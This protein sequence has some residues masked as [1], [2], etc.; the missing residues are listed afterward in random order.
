VKSFARE[1]AER[2]RSTAAALRAL[3]AEVAGRPLAPGKWSRQQVVGHMIDSASNN[4]QRFVRAQLQDSMV[5]PAYD[6]DDW[7]RAQHYDAAG[8][9]ELVALWESFNLHVAHVMATAD[10]NALTRA[11]SEHNL[12][13][14]ASRTVPRSDPVTLEYF[15]RDYVDHFD[16]HVKQL[17]LR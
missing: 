9:T 6:Q 7:V 3:S 4:H 5:F 2:V 10:A 16:H 14:I 17:D 13:T 12:D 8:W 11:R 15:M 1:F